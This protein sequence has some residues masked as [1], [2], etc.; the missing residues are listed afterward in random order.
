MCLIF[1]PVKN[2]SFVTVVFGKLTLHDYDEDSNASH[3]THFPTHSGVSMVSGVWRLF[4]F[5]SRILHN[6]VWLLCTLFQCKLCA[7]LYTQ[8]PYFRAKTFLV[9]FK[10]QVAI[11]SRHKL[12][13]A[14]EMY[15]SNSLKKS[16]CQLYL[17]GPLQITKAT[18][19]TLRLA[20]KFQDLTAHCLVF[21]DQ[22]LKFKDFTRL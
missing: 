2:N 17:I 14:C 7:N 18:T 9:L 4:F 13:F 22:I 8:F 3:N 16:T 20:L 1:K 21:T 10:T 12:L 5:I 11:F 15:I 19:K 6:S